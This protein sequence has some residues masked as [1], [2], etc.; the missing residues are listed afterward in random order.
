MSKL[1]KRL[2]YKKYQSGGIADKAKDWWYNANDIDA[3][4]K[5][6]KDDPFVVNWLKD[7]ETKKRADKMFVNVYKK[8]SA[9][10]FDIPQT[11]GKYKLWESIAA[12]PI[13]EDENKEAERMVKLYKKK[14]DELKSKTFIDNLLPAAISSVKNATIYPADFNVDQEDIDYYNAT[15]N[16]QLN[17]TS[18]ELDAGANGQYFRDK[19]VIKIAPEDMSNGSTAS[20][21]ELSHATGILAPTIDG[22]IM[23]DRGNSAFYKK[24]DY[25]KNM[26]IGEGF[27]PDD[28]YT[29]EHK[30]Y[31]SR[32]GIWPRM[33]EIRK[34][35][36][37]HP[38]EEF[39]D[40]HIEKLKELDEKRKPNEYSPY[41]DIK[42]VYPDDNDIKTLFNKVVD[43]NVNGRKQHE[44]ISTMTAKKGGILYKQ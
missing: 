35:L 5:T 3:N 25:L 14:Y 13:N 26:S 28:K 42:L 44:K 17:W 20:T 37:L 6:S 9:E 33:M 1:D 38:G 12:D 21:H 40:K 29:T 22:L 43:A 39:T 24:P 15:R 11:F 10:E 36:N 8:K 34:R 32:D 2:L 31:L 23:P 7:P 4:H 16:K 27:R 19:N 41:S 18:E 30:Q